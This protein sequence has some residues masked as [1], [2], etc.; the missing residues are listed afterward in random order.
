MPRPRYTRDSRCSRSNKHTS[1]RNRAESASPH[2]RNEGSLRWWTRYSFS[3]RADEPARAERRHLDGQLPHLRLSF[4]EPPRPGRR[5]GF[6]PLRYDDPDRFRPEADVRHVE[7][8]GDRPPVRVGVIEAHDRLG[9]SAQRAPH[10]DDR[11][12][13]DA[14]AVVPLRKRR[15]VRAGDRAG[16]QHLLR[17]DAAYEETAGLLRV[18]PR[19]VSP[20]R[21]AHGTAD[22]HLADQPRLDRLFLELP[23]E[24]CGHLTRCCRKKK[25]PVRVRAGR[26]DLPLSPDRTLSAYVVHHRAMALR[27]GPSTA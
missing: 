10:V 17:L 11:P 15:L 27:P 24:L 3:F 8:R 14:E 26:G 2:G 6:S 5:S 21:I 16:D 20:Q 18:S 22:H 13:I 25:T 1:G 19:R 9:T 4:V 12:R 23:G 7:R